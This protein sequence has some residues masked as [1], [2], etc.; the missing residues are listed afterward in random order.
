MSFYRKSRMTALALPLS[1]AAMLLFPAMTLAQEEADTRKALVEHEFK[2]IDALLKSGFPRI[3]EKVISAAAVK[4]PD[5]KGMLEALQIRAELEGGKQDEVKKKIDARADQ[6]SL[7]TWL[8]RLELAKSYLRYQKYNDAEAIYKAFFGKF[9][10]GVPEAAKL[11]YWESIKYYITLLESLNRPQEA[12]TYY[13]LAWEQSPT[14]DIKYDSRAQ[15]LQALLVRAETTDNGG[16][17]EKLLKEAEA[18]ANQMVWRQDNYFGDAINGLAHVRMLRGNIKGAQEMINDYTDMLLQIHKSYREEDPDGTKGYLRLSPL[19]Q[20]RY[21][22]GKMLFDQAKAEIAKG[23][24]ANDETIKNLILGERDPQ[25]KKRNKQGAFYHL[26]TVAMEYPESQSA[27]LATDYAKEIAE[28]IRERYNTVVEVKVTD[29]QRAKMREQTYQSAAI[30]YDSGDY[31]AAVE[32]YQKAVS[33]SGLTNQAIVALD[34]IARSYVNMVGTGSLDK[35]TQLKLNAVTRTLAE[36]FSGIPDLYDRAGTQLRNLADFYGEVNLT[37][38]R[39]EAQ[40]LFVRYYSKHPAAIALKLEMASQDLD[41]GK[42]D[43]AETRLKSI[44]ADADPK[45]Q[46]QYIANAYRSLAKLYGDVAKASDDFKVRVTSTKQEMD[47]AKAFAALYDGV[48]RPGIMGALAQSAVA[49]ANFHY[50]E[51][52]AR[53]EKYKKQAIKFHTDASKIYDKL[54]RELAKNENIYTSTSEERKTA[55]TILSFTLY[56]LATSYQRLAALDN[57]QGY[58]EKAI[59]AFESYYLKFPESSNAPE[60]YMQIAT[61]Q[62]ATNDVEGARKTLEAL[63]KKYPDSD[64]AKN[65]VPKLAEALVPISTAAAREQYKKMFTAGG[66]YSADQYLKAAE[67]LQNA[68]DFSLAEEA[69]ACAIKEATAKK[70]RARL[71][72]AMLARTR[73]L[74]SDKKTPEAYTQLQEMLKAFGNSQQAVPANL[75]M[76]DVAAAQ[77]G[78]AKTSD[79]RNTFMKNAKDAAEFVKRYSKLEDGSD[80]VVKITELNLAVARVARQAFEA[81]KAA[82]GERLSETC[83]SAQNAFYVVMYPEGLPQTDDNVSKYVQDAYKAYVDLSLERARFE[84][85]PTLKQEFFQE[86]VKFSQEYLDIFANGTYR[87]AMN[88][89]K[90]DA[91]ASLK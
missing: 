5:Q 49:E 53:E 38:Y 54:S 14:E 40:Q 32:E 58:Q 52:F 39:T 70:D 41:A 47:T 66:Q 62:T 82:K 17:K 50:A 51:I 18:L 2:Y 11:T 84:S 73:A 91:E 43:V 85:D 79:E 24:K 76:L 56:R 15:Y 28:I 6:S 7:D 60:A 29:E 9:P 31:A 3:A 78:L 21:L 81:E 8:L 1:V 12:L 89:S 20:C 35:V 4:W 80:D 10:K 23:D 74:L 88:A 87:D 86:V 36:G 19:P 67:V 33:E 37:N 30:K 75:L 27:G 65:S 83:G 13:K 59:A 63:A 44:I 69:A 25:T 77:I 71:S 61:L 55:Q 16:E 42:T 68:R 22:L 72:R 64:A 46:K 57:T 26:L 48:Q 90:Q 34:R 45:T